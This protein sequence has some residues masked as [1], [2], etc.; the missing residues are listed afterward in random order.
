[1]FVKA[2]AGASFAGYSHRCD[3]VK[4]E[5]TD[6]KSCQKL[7]PKFVGQ[8]KAVSFDFDDCL[9]LSE[10]EKK[11]AIYDSVSEFDGSTE[12]LDAIMQTKGHTR[13]TII[14]AFA[15]EVCDRGHSE[16]HWVDVARGL[17]ARCN[18]CMLQRVST[19][20]YVVGATSTLVQLHRR[21]IPIYLNSATP[22]GPLQDVIA[23]RGI[24]RIFNGVFG[25]PPGKVCSSY[26]CFL[27]S[28]PRCVIKV[29]NLERISE[30][31]GLSPSQILHVGKKFERC[32]NIV[33]VVSEVFLLVLF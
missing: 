19:C 8:I 1:L 9:V 12:I 26:E 14:D 20:P 4:Q 33:Q 25:S 29:A 17:A 2:I 11:E 23:A 5:P 27:T 3:Y 7:D 31:E 6:Q 18:D 22:H 24:Y 16:K 13:Y 32:A 15:R 21:G 28:N 30:L 10:R